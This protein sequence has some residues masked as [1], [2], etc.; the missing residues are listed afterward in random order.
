MGGGY[1]TYSFLLIVVNTLTLVEFKGVV[2]ISRYTSLFYAE[3][4]VLPLKYWVFQ[5]RHMLSC[6]EDTFFRLLK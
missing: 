1:C 2:I 3:T 6:L 4:L 5:D